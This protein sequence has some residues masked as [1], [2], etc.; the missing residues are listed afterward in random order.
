[1]M[2]DN[3][4]ICGFKRRHIDLTSNIKQD[5]SLAVM[6]HWGVVETNKTGY[7]HNGTEQVCNVRLY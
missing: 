6:F 4:Y 1:M 2:N 5:T 7:H 3:I